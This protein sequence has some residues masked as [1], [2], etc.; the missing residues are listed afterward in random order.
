[1]CTLKTL[2]NLPLKR[3]NHHFL[4]SFEDRGIYQIEELTDNG[5][6][7][8][9]LDLENLFEKAFDEMK[10]EKERL[11]E[12]I[13]LEDLEP[14]LKTKELLL[15]LLFENWEIPGLIFFPVLPTGLIKNGLLSGLI[16]DLGHTFS[17][18]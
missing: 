14:S 1:V 4:E 18:V 2:S 12:M 5:G 16:L 7:R 9:K 17:R 3:K 13:F 10:I 11:G 8:C 6:F 15:E